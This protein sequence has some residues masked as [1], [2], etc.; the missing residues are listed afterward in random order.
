MKLVKRSESLDLLRWDLKIVRGHE[1]ITANVVAPGIV[2]TSMTQQVPE[3]IMGQKLNQ[4]L[5]KRPGVPSEIAS[6]AVFLASHLGDYVN[7]ELIRVD[8]GIRF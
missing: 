2:D 7:G 3:A 8:G 1:G 5:I 4:I 6:V